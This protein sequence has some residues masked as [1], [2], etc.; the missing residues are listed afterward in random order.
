[1]GLPGSIDH[2]ACLC[3]TSVA[4]AFFVTA[5]AFGGSDGYDAA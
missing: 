1:M 4:S 3:G 2:P 5:A